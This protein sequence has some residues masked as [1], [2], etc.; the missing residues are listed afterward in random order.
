MGMSV[1][2]CCNID[3]EQICQWVSVVTSVMHRYVSVDVV[4]LMVK[5]YASG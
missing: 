2:E 5:R 4:T 3:G 1:D